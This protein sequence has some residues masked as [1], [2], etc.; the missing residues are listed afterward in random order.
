MIENFGS[1]P[2][3]NIALDTS[4]ISD[5]RSEGQEKR[6]RYRLCIFLREKQSSFLH[7]RHRGSQSNAII[8]LNLAIMFRQADVLASRSSLC[9]RRPCSLLKLVPQ[10]HYRRPYSIQS[11]EEEIAQLPDINP[12]ALSIT[13]T[14]TPKPILPPEELIFGRTFTGKHATAFLESN[15]TL[16]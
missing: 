16:C 11:Q 7:I 14:T 13:R 9:M 6:L 1:S 10:W 15:H 4:S 12:G 2:S 8:D 3:P 5:I